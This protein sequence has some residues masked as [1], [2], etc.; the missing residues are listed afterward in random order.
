MYQIV[1]QIKK[2]LRRGCRKCLIFIA[3][4]RNRT[5][6]LLI[7]SYNVVI[8]V[9][10]TTCKSTGYR[11][12]SA[13]KVRKKV[14]FLHPFLLL[15]MVSVKLTLFKQKK[16]KDGRHPVML[17]VNCGKVRRIAIGFQATLKEWD[18]NRKLFRRS[19]KDY[20]EKNKR[21]K[22][23]LQRA[24]EIVDRLIDKDGEL[25]FD[26]FKTIFQYE[27]S[28]TPQEVKRRPRKKKAPKKKTFYAFCEE[29]IAEKKSLGKIGTYQSYRDSVKA[30]RK[31]KPKDFPFG[32]YDY[33]LLKGFE[34]SLF[35]RGHKPGGIGVRMRGL[36]AIYYEAMRRGLVD[37]KLNPYSTVTNKDGYSLS[38][39]KSDKIPK[40]MTKEELERFKAFDIEQH[41]KL[42]DSWRLFMFSFKMFGMNFIDMSKL[43]QSNLSRGRLSYQRQKTGKH[44][45]LLVT[46]DAQKIIDHYAT[47]DSEYLFPILRGCDGLS[48]EEQRKACYKWLYRTKSELR[49]IADILGIE[50]HITFYT[51]RHTSATTLKRNGTPTDVISEALGHSDLAVTQHY[52]SKFED[53]V[54]DEAIGR[55]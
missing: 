45:S 23:V 32:Q 4:C 36:K 29:Y 34:T 15:K 31:Y 47:D 20:S 24:N 44:F 22:S 53:E 2:H 5:S 42:A 14:Q 50:T 27:S 16:L 9:E 54:L 37:K 33:A 12:G 43:K 25:D 40:A 55:L 46:E 48:A 18:D 39:L 3:P 19:A 21:L 13:K 6:D 30:L 17:Y 1:Y 26:R 35:A 11:I 7:T 52:L 28:T 49:K 10:I 38:K 41:P 51:A 8:S